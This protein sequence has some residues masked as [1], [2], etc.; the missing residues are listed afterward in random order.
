MSN[1]S[2]FGSSVIQMLLRTSVKKN[3]YYEIKDRVD[4]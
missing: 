4:E 1:D 3:L 2:G